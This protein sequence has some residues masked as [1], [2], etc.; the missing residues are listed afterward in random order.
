M[1]MER[2]VVELL[3]SQPDRNPDGSP[4]RIQIRG[5]MYTKSE[6][7]DCWSSDEEMRRE[8]VRLILGLKIHLAGRRPG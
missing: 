2:E 4:W 3:R 6:I 5:H 7:L 1:S 8:V